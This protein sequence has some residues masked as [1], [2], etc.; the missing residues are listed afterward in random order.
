MPSSKKTKVIADV[1]KAILH[2][3]DNRGSSLKKIADI[4]EDKVSINDVKKALKFGIDNGLIKRTGCNF[5]LGLDLGHLVRRSTDDGDISN[6]IY[7]AR[8][9]RKGSKRRRR[10]GRRRRRHHAGELSDSECC[11]YCETDYSDASDG[12]PVREHRR[13][14]GRRRRGSKRRRGHRR[15]RRTADPSDSGATTEED[16]GNGMSTDSASTAEPKSDTK[17]HAD[18]V[19]FGRVI[20]DKNEKNPNPADSVKMVWSQRRLDKRGVSESERKCSGCNRTECVCSSIK[21]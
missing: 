8:R 3:K 11:E 15:R 18:Y 16:G 12:T 14:G 9:R 6:K 5:R 10:S 1:M 2:L 13:R 4:V 17:R 20:E 21:K 7:M 19:D